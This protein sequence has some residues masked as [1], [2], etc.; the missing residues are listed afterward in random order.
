MNNSA[1]NNNPLRHSLQPGLASVRSLMPSRGW[2]L[3]SLPE[4]VH[5]DG[6]TKRDYSH[7]CTAIGGR[8]V[9]DGMP[10]AVRISAC[11]R[12]AAAQNL[13]NVLV[14]ASPFTHP[15]VTSL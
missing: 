1:I 11:L 7:G 5:D 15:Q 9:S 3:R 2:W 14:N 4:A 6:Q 10:D 8:A 12:R 13:D